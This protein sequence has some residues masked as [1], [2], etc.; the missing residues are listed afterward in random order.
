MAL[1]AA[2]A[3][4]SVPQA[5]T[6]MWMRGDEAGDVGHHVDEE[7]VGAAAGAQ[8]R[9]G[10]VDAGGVGDLGAALHGELGGFGELAL[11]GADD[12]E[13]H[14]SLPSRFRSW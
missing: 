5:T 10:D 11:E 9:H 6:G 4:V 3:L 7:Q 12:E 8:R 1:T 13:P 14:V 2:A